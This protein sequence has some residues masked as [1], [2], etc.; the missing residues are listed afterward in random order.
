VRRNWLFVAV[1]AA[2]LVIGG[3]AILGR[4]TENDKSIPADTWAEGV[5]TELADW[6]SAIV[7]LAETTGEPPTSESIEEN[8][9]A[10]RDATEELVDNLRALGPPQTESSEEVEQELDQQ[11]SDLEQAFDE[12]EA[13]LQEVADS[14]TGLAAKIAAL[15]G[16][17]KA[18]VQQGSD[19]LGTLEEADPVGE[20]TSALQNEPACQQ[21]R[22]SR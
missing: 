17:V 18:I 20:V 9:G 4:T 8:L 7:A 22:S 5:C 15:S 6:E 21:L 14:D 19:A 13:S 10:A 1:I 16:D 2:L 11:V 12:L 3:A